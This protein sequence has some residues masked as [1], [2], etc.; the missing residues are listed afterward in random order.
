MLLLILLFVLC[1]M[2]F[3][4]ATQ[5]DNNQNASNPKHNNND[6]NKSK[7]KKARL[8]TAES[9]FWLSENNLKHVFPEKKTRKTNTELSHICHFGGLAGGLC[10]FVSS[11]VHGF[12]FLIAFLL[13]ILWVFCFLYCFG[14]NKATLPNNKK[15]NPNRHQNNGN[16]NQNKS[17]KT[18]RQPKQ[19]KPQLVTWQSLAKRQPKTQT[20]TNF[21]MNL[22][23]YE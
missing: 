16:S 2:F 11:S 5:H 17:T 1:W 18:I 13:F 22:L 12:H 7:C 14:T 10:Y 15:I 23:Q 8:P 4:N 6:N 9:L 3:Q 21:S 20:T 19:R